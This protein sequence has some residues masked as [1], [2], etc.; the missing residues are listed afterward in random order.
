MVH[1]CTLDDPWPLTSWQKRVVYPSSA[2]SANSVHGSFSRVQKAKGIAVVG[3]KAGSSLKTQGNKSKAREQLNITLGAYHKYI[4]QR[5]ENMLKLFVTW[6]FFTPWEA[7]WCKLLCTL[8]SAVNS[9]GIGGH[10]PCGTLWGEFSMFLY[11]E[12]LRNQS[13]ALL[14]HNTSKCHLGAKTNRTTDCLVCCWCPYDQLRTNEPYVYPDPIT[15][16][17]PISPCYNSICLQLL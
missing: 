8:I 1:S 11:W 14:I 9:C 2:D 3:N 17:N 10:L 15:L 7:F 16:A 12:T 6:S 5:T 4:S 13:D